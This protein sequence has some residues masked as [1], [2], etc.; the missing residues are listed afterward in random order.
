MKLVWLITRLNVPLQTSK[1]L[2]ILEFDVIRTI[3]RLTKEKQ[4]ITVLKM[5]RSARERNG[6]TQAVEDYKG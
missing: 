5:E 4:T 2:R 3:F 6:C 1:Q